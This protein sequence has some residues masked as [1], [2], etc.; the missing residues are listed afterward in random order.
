M[1]A[2]S[3]E[4]PGRSASWARLSRFEQRQAVASGPRASSSASSG[5]NRSKI[6]FLAP[7]RTIVPWW[8]AGRKPAAQFAGPLGANPRESGSTTNVGRFS[9]RLPRP[10]ETQAPM[11]GKPGSTKPVFCMNVAGPCTF[12]LATIAGRNAM[13]STQPARCG[14]RSLIHWP[15]WPYCRHFQGL[16]ITAPGHALE[17]LDLAAGIEL[18]AVLADQG[19]FVVERVALAGRAG[20]EQ[21]DDAPGLGPVM[22]PA[23]EL[24]AR[25]GRFPGRPG[26]LGARRPP[27]GEPARAPETAA[28]RA[29]GSFGDPGRSWRG[30]AGLAR[31]MAWP[32]VRPQGEP[33]VGRPVARLAL[34]LLAGRFRVRPP[35][36]YARPSCTG[37][38][39][40]ASG[41]S[42]RPSDL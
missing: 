7:G 15:H 16:V 30:A 9:L 19:G 40:A 33:Q 6:G 17:Q 34:L 24:G 14:T 20:H 42:P 35:T 32:P 27:G 31:V 1:R 5:G 18:L 3:R 38:L 11:L 41:E 8:A 23:V 26:R 22:Q 21:L 25:R 29:R 12:D 37:Y 39:A 13:S 10:Y 36:R 28:V 2:S 4:S